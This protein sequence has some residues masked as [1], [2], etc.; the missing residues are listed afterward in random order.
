MSFMIDDFQAEEVEPSHLQPA[1][2][3]LKLPDPRTD[4]CHKVLSSSLFLL[5]ECLARWHL[6]DSRNIPSSHPEVA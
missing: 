5:K 2:R 1:R 4:Y 3:A 6:E